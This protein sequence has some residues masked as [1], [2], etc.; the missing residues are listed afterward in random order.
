MKPTHSY[1]TLLTGYI[2]GDLTAAERQS[3]ERR[4]ETDAVLRGQ[5]TQLQAAHATMREAAA[6]ELPSR[7]F[8]LKVMENL[9]Q[10]PLQA[11]APE[12]SIRKSVLLLAGALIAAAG[13]AILLS[14]GM[15]DAVTTTINLAGI[16]LPGEVV[17]QQL[18]TF[19][20][21]GRVVM[22]TVIILNIVL[23]WIVL[24]RTIL[25]PLFLKRLS[26]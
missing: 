1:D 10:L 26:S 16:K 14:T 20:I 13:T 12:Q 11:Q 17:K 19:N 8:T 9:H 23:G 15:F 25:K 22:N 5:L 4:L 21:S 18:P 6:P 7:N 2:D 3:L 24:D